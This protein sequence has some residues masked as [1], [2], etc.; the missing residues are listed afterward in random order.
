MDTIETTLL[1]A[2]LNFLIIGSFAGLILGATLIFRPHWLKWAS[3]IC[4][5]W[6][7]TRPLDKILESTIKLDPWFHR[8]HRAVGAF[9]LAGA[10]YILYFFIVQIDKASAIVSMTNRFHLPPAYI[11][12]LSE[13]LILI[14]LLGATFALIISLLM[15][16]SPNL[17]RKFEHSAN[18]WVSLRRA[19]KPL[20]TWHNGV[21]EFTFRHTQQMG[22]MLILGSVYLM[23][24]LTF[25]A[26]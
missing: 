23:V 7:P 18:E 6:I 17:F 22:V 12:A 5:R 15:I 1:R 21:D 26:R 25:W 10:L 20:E 19:L 8:Y 13:Q 14:E 4:N 9:I 3:L 16:F 11:A 24:P 2:L